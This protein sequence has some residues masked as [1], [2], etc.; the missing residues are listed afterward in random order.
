MFHCIHIGIC[1][2]NANSK[3]MYSISFP[4][5]LPPFQ[6]TV[7]DVVTVSWEVTLDRQ[8]MME[9]DYIGVFE[10]HDITAPI[11]MDDLLDSRLRGVSNSNNGQIS[12]LMDPT[13]FRGSKLY[14]C[15][16]L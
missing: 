5:F 3:S 10:C 8:S 13:K 12:W 7:G 11:E 1:V 16:T 4:S 14:S 6:V 15:L 2:I 9:S